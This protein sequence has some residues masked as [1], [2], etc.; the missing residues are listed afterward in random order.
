MKLDV[1]SRK[2]VATICKQAADHF[3]TPDIVI[4]NAGI[5]QKAFCQ[6]LNE[7]MAHKVIVV[8]CVSNMW[9]TREF[10]PKMLE[11]NSG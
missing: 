2:D 9:I 5:M 10:L 6:D 8:N 4:N 7:A 11:R 3:G 1:S